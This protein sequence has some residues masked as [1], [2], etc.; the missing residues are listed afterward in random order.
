MSLQQALPR[1]IQ[2]GMGIGVSDW[3]LAR[4]VSAAGQLG[5]VSGTVLDAVL[6]RRLQRGDPGGH[7]RRALDAFPHPDIARRI[8]DDYFIPGGKP[9]AVAYKLGPLPRLDPAPASVELLVAANFCEVWLARQGHDNPVGINY[10]EKLQLVTLPSLYGALLAGVDT[11]IM[12]GGIPL[13]IPGVLD[14]LARG[15]TVSLNID[16]EGATGSQSWTQRFD[17][18]SLG[19]PSTPIAL[20]RPRFCAIVSSDTVA[21]AMQRRATGRVDGLVVEHHSAGGHNAPPRRSHE[22][23][24]DGEPYGPR[25]EPNLA[26][27][28]DL[29]LPFWLGGGYGSPSRLQEALARG[30]VGVQVGS[31]F[32]HCRE[33][34]FTAEIKR[35]FLERA[36]AG[37]LTVETDLQ[38][39]STGYPFK[40]ARELSQGLASRRRVCDLGYLRQ[41]YLRPDGAIGY[42]C[43]AEPVSVYTAKGGSSEET[44]GRECLCNGLLAAIGLG[45]PL[46]SGGVE[47]PI[48]T[49]GSDLS[50]VRPLVQRF[51]LDYSAADVLAYM[52]G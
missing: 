48:V 11:V 37:G 41:P 30:A 33:S 46:A 23:H 4:A 12:G 35:A 13:A 39:S 47:P 7:L 15:Q 50:W 31:P 14:G 52:L 26:R 2:G 49:A 6:I 10:L 5:V 44:A 19:E 45:Q 42:R 3:R 24:T 29:G 17:P 20:R 43:P 32:A 25:D 21:R 8:L 34:G 9:A 40:V 22:A 18:R 51:G 27:I 36:L 28:A 1:L 38:A 16:V